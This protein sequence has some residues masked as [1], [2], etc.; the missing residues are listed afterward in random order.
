MVICIYNPSTLKS[1]MGDRD[2]RV[3]QNLMG[4]LMEDSA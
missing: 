1:K 3:T 2:K 4:Q